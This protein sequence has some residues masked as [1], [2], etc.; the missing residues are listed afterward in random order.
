[1]FQDFDVKSAP[2]TVAPRIAQLRQAMLAAKVDAFVVPHSDE[3]QNEYLPA[4]AERLAWLSGFTGSAGFAIVTA[5]TAVLFVDGR[6]T[7]QAQAQTDTT[8]FTLASLIDTPPENWLAANA[9]TGWRIGYDPHLL[10]LSQE[11]RFAKK[12]T[13]AGAGLIPI[14]NQVDAVW[15]DRPRQ[16]AGKIS[17]HLLKHAGERARDKLA[18][19]AKLTATAGSNACLLSDPVSI[20]WAFNIRG[21]DVAHTPLV[22][23]RALIRKQDRPLLFIAAEKLDRQCHAYLNQLADLHEPAGLEAQLAAVSKGAK[24]ICD[25]DRVSAALCSIVTSAGGQIIKQRDPVVL[26]RATKNQAEIAGARAAHLRDGLA[27]TRFL[28]WLDRQSAG[29]LDEIAA[30]RQLE[31]IRLQ[32]APAFDRK[33]LDLS[34]DTI[35]AAGP[36]AAKPH[37]RVDT[38]SNRRIANNSLYLIDSGGQYRDGTTDITRTIAIGTPPQGASIDFTLVLKGHIAIATARFPAGTRGVDIDPLARIALWRQGRDFAHG[39]GHGIG[40]YLSVHEGPQSISRRGMEPLLPGMIISNEPGFYRE[41]QYGIRIE[42]LVLVNG[43]QFLPGGNVETMDFET[44]S[45]APIDQRLVEQHL[46]TRDELTWFDAY[47][48]RVFAELSP[49]LDQA[50][51]A[52]LKKACAPLRG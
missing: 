10:T 18:N 35:S 21:S 1:M 45:L 52:W 11:S 7:L 27:V 6:Y 26:P 25:P 37:Y 9:K 51:R 38:A 16:P 49:H 36:N 3:Y 39:T 48:A 42:N 28:A 4:C 33:L 22:L 17:I 29:S 8:V 14:A 15:H 24:I 5:D 32:T 13:S 30:A 12:L 46:L 34:F 50:D 23:A 41:G 47:H 20:A 2:Q 31:T 40:S 43:L 19:L 44:L